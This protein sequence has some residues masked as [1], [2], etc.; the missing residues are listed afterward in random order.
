MLESPTAAIELAVASSFVEVGLPRTHLMAQNLS[1]HKACTSDLHI[2]NI[3]IQMGVFG[4]FS[5][6]KIWRIFGNAEN[7]ADKF[8]VFPYFKNMEIHIS[9]LKIWKKYLHGCLN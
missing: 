4:L 5:T 2:Q 8:S 1:M 7:S 6:F 9:D 3:E